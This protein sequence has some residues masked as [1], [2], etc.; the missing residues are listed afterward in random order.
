[1][2]DVKAAGR[3]ADGSDVRAGLA[4][5][6]ESRDRSDPAETHRKPIDQPLGQLHR[7]GPKQRRGGD[8]S[9]SAQSGSDKGGGE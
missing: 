1:V 7:F 5:G 2:R 6:E 4:V 9:V 3:S 8:R